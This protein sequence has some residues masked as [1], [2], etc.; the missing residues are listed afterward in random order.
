MIV[1]VKR[2]DVY[3]ADLDPVKG[4]E[5]GGQRR[6]IIVQTD[7]MNRI[8]TYTVVVI[9]PATTKDVESKRRF[10]DNVYIPKDE[11][12]F[13]KEA[14]ALCGQ[15]RAISHERLIKKQDEVSNETMGQISAALRY[16]LAL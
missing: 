12:G 5:Q 4:S 6:V 9:V 15:V 14:V 2:G 7:D 11:G 3:E 13:T 1:R 8:K 16:T 10:P